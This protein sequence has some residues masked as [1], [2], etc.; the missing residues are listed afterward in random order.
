MALGGRISRRFHQEDIMAA[1]RMPGIDDIVV[2]GRTIDEAML[3]ESC[4]TPAD[5]SWVS[6]RTHNSGWLPRFYLVQG[7]KGVMVKQ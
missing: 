2:V 1:I 7:E 4:L 3:S 5:D 6:P